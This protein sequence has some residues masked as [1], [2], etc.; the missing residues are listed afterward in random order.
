MWG[1]EKI[2]WALGREEEGRGL[3]RCGQM[4]TNKVSSRFQDAKGQMLLRG[5]VS[6][7]GSR[8]ANA[9]HLG[10]KRVERVL[11]L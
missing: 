3:D 4:F 10:E 7:P 1:D 11:G 9:R 6:C 8:E 5:L 2:A